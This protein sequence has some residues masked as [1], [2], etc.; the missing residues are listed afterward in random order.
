G[1]VGIGAVIPNGLAADAGLQSGG[2]ITAVGGKKVASIEEYR[3][4]IATFKAGDKVKVSVLRGKETKEVEATLAAG[5]RGPGGG[6]GGPRPQQTVPGRPYLLDAQVGGQRANVQ[7]GQ[8]Q[9]GFQTG[10]VFV[11]KDSGET[12]TRVNSLNP[13]PFYFSNIRVDPTDDSTIYVLGDT[14][15]WKSVNGGAKF[16]AGPARGVHPD[17]H[18]MWIDPKN[19]KHMLIG[20]DGGFYVTYD[21]GTTWDHLNILALGQF[22]HVAVDNRKPYRVYGGLQDNGSWGGPS[23]VLRAQG[24][25]NDDWLFL[26]GGDGFV[27]RVD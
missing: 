5:G 1:G 25:V 9:E 16:V 24:P 21:Q 12:W 6:G 17:H 19:G 26:N 7:D 20:C 10:G 18:T 4:L 11:S 3:S 8:G 22:Y 2:V 15:L 14:S 23:Q 13:R 27:C